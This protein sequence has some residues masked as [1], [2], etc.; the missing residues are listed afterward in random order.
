M[1]NKL[2]DHLINICADCESVIEWIE[3]EKDIPA[4]IRYLHIIIDQ[5]NEIIEQVKANEK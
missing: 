3:Q 2:S 5:L 1:E 4:S